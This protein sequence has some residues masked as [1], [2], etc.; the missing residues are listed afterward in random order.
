MDYM[1]LILRWIHVLPAA[2][3]LGGIVFIR[4]C[5]LYPNRSQ[6][7]TVS[8]FDSD[9]S[10]RRQ[11]MKL[12]SISTL[13]LLVSGLY[14]GINKIL[15]YKLTPD[16]HGLFGLKLLLGLA[17]F[18]LAAVLAGRSDR[19]KRMRQREIFW[20]NWLLTLAIIV[21]LIG[22]YMKVASQD[23]I[24]KPVEASTELEA[25]RISPPLALLD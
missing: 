17:V 4:Y 1:S 6:T 3:M 12:V 5:L 19:A 11:W 20:L 10:L 15:V 16:Y 25:D 23:A 7:E 21:V 9:D 22:G 18:Y 14:N 2:L 24:R 8:L 13:L